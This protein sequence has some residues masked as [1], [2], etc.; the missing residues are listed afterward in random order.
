MKK[1]FLFLFFALS[2]GASAQV[3]NNGPG[4]FVWTN[5]APVHNPGTSGAKFAVNKLTFEWYEHSTGTTWISSGERIQTISGST[6]PAYTPGIHDSEIVI[7]GVDSLYRY[8]AGAWRHINKGGA[9]YTAGT[10]IAISGGN[11]ISN[12]GLL[13]STN[14][15]GDI[16]GT[17]SNLQIVA[18]AVGPTE[19]ASTAVTAGSYTSTNLTVDADGRITAASNGTGGG[20]TSVTTDA[21]LTGDGT[22]GTPLGVAFPILAPDGSAEAPSYSFSTSPGSG[23]SFQSGGLR[24]KSSIATTLEMTAGAEGAVFITAENVYGGLSGGTVTIT[25]GSNLDNARSGGNIFV[26]S[27]SGSDGGTFNMQSGDGTVGIGGDFAMEAGSSIDVGGGAFTMTAG[28]STNGSGGGFTA[29]AGSGV[30][31]GNFTM[32]AG[33]STADEEQAGSFIARG[34]QSSGADGQGGNLYLYGGEGVSTS[35]GG[36]IVLTGGVSAAGNGGNI[37]VSAGAGPSQMQNGKIVMTGNGVVL[38]TLTT[39]QRNALTGVTLGTVI[40]NSTTSTMQWYNGT[41]WLNL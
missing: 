26:L 40:I 32:T 5:G 17:F 18:G 11:V 25:S 1:I 41:T 20:L 22:S 36:G 14:A 6:S 3:V 30:F 9:T 35:N 24:V 2:F 27:G 38:P 28:N 21:T 19:L 37:T 23:V 33:N 12:T 7:N 29:S 4:T 39:T 31:G 8:R 13:T 15:S 16:S 34:G 10:G